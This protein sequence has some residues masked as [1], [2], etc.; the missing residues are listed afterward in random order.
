MTTGTSLIGAG[1]LCAL[2]GIYF[3]IRIVSYLKSRGEP[4]SLFLFRL[5]WFYYMRRY[6]ELTILDTGK[7]GVFLACYKTVMLIALVLIV[8]G[9]LILGE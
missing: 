4:V 5:K 9:A 6:S 1:F 8:A 7:P 2:L 3:M